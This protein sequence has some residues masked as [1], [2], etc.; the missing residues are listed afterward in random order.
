MKT[1]KIAYVA[2]GLSVVAL[3]IALVQ[4]RA[5]NA[6]LNAPTSSFN[7]DD[8]LDSAAPVVRKR[9]AFATTAKSKSWTISRDLQC[10]PGSRQQNNP[11]GT[12]TCHGVM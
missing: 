11:D 12:K 3:G 9:S 5:L 2:L 4:R 1:E 7:G 6:V 8:T 10:P